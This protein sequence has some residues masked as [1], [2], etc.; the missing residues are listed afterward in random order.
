MAV[1]RYVKQNAEGGWDVLKEGH[2]RSAIH[3]PSREAAISRARALVRRE[4]GGE[5]RVMNDVGKVMD[6]RT[7]GR[8]ATPRR[9]T[10]V[11]SSGSRSA[12]GH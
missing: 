9:R 11:S 2:R 5:V 8:P 12:K 7:V 1:N 10:A 3:A 6:T 4:G